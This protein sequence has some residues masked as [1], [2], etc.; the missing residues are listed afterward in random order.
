[1]S[2]PGP[3]AI[4]ARASRARIL[5]VG[6]GEL[7]RGLAGAVRRVMPAVSECRSLYDA[8]AEVGNCPAREPIAAVIV[9][10][11]CEGFD[12]EAVAGAFRRVDPL[13][14]LIL[15]VRRE[16]E[17]LIAGA[18][19]EGFEHSLL[20]PVDPD[21]LAPVLR[22]VGAMEEIRAPRSTGFVGTAPGTP[23][24]S[25]PSSPS[26]PPSGAP[27]NAASMDGRVPVRGVVELAIEDAIAG[28]SRT[29]PSESKPSESRTSESRTSESRPS[30]SRPSESRPAARTPPAATAPANAPLPAEAES[31]PKRPARPFEMPALRE[32]GRARDKARA[33]D[34][35]EPGDTTLVR[36]LLAS[37]PLEDAALRVLRHH[38]ATDDVRFV[39]AVRAGEEA[40]VGA[41]RRRLHEAEVRGG[42]RVHGALISSSLDGATLAPWAAWLSHWLDLEDTQRELRRLA[43]TDELTGA[44]NRRAFEEVIRDTM[45]EA[46]VNRRTLSLMVLDIDDFKR[47]N[48][49]FGHQVGDDVLR[50]TVELLRSC[51]RSGDHVFRIGG[52]EFVVLFCDA[53]GP[54]QGG[55]GAPESVEDIARRF[56]RAVNELRLPQ[57]GREG[58]GT[59]TVSAGVAVFP[60]EGLDADALVRRADERAMESK[61]NGKNLI[62]FGPGAPGG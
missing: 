20:L 31:R 5:V 3:S 34:E 29:K 11:E 22:E 47:Y 16:Q 40:A 58:P 30:E 27:S 53:S 35:G 21:E 42:A 61:R 50:E 51:I 24:S 43:Y 8:V 59:F 1:M 18:I 49:E 23:P 10:A 17:D 6:H 32:G 36:A 7:V 41:E 2:A 54:R 4:G 15:A 60:W 52:D 19:A 25:T 46:L 37:A 38:L 45:A 57:L 62:T 48:D 55:G 56:Q 13:V 12:L 14:P 28:A 44:G 33:R 26:S 9:S 39:A